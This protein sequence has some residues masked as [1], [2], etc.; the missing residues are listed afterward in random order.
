MSANDFTNEYKKKIDA[1]QTLYR[2]KGNVE[3]LEELNSKTDNNVG[4]TWK[5]KE[6]GN[7]YCWNKT[8]WVNVGTD[9]D[10]SAYAL[11]AD[12]ET[13][14]DKT[15]LENAIQE[16]A[17]T[18]VTEVATQENDGLMSKENWKKLNDLEIIEI[19]QEDGQASDTNVYSAEAVNNIIKESKMTVTVLYNNNSGSNVGSIVLADKVGNYQMIDILYKDNW[20]LK[21]S[22]RVSEHLS[23][24]VVQLNSTRMPST[25]FQTWSRMVQLT[26]NIITNFDTVYNKFWASYSGSG[27]AVESDGIYI[28]KVIGYNYN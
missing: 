9:I 6:D 12:L 11:Q 2:F 20:A 18:V 17:D 26:E 16:V 5:C 10:L 28:Y 14:V 1:L 19:I 25:D 21:N 8:E 15:E 3:T 13:K 7:N 4:D 24:N 27:G 22:V 23:G